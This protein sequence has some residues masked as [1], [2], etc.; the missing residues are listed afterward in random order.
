MLHQL[1]LKAHI[2][3]SQL[4]DMLIA[5]TGVGSVLKQSSYDDD[6]EEDDDM[7]DDSLDVFGITSVVNLTSHK[8]SIIYTISF[9]YNFFPNIYTIFFLFLGNSVHTTVI[10][11][12]RR[13]D[14]RTR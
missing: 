10:Y 7:D 3:I 8:V 5:Q 12:I 6:D 1:F 9:L 13:T 2:D 11:T 14:Q 4:S